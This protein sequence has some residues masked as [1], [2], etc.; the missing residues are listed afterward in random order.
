M[1]QKS[2]GAIDT[3]ITPFWRTDLELHEW[4]PEPWKS[5]RQLP[6]ML[7]QMYSAPTGIPPYGEYLEQAR[8]DG[9]PRALPGSSMA[10]VLAKMDAD[11][12]RLGILMPLTRGPQPDQDMSSVI[13]S[14]TN[15]WLSETWLDVP[16]ADG[17]FLGTIRVNPADPDTAV[18]E[19]QRWA[20]HPRMVQVGV[21][22]DAWRPYGQ[23]NY[24]PIWEAA[25]RYDLPIAV[26]ADGGASANFAPTMVGYPRKHI[27]Y[28]SQ[29]SINFTYHLASF[30]MEGVFERLPNLR[31]VFADGGHDMVTTL[32]WRMDADFAIARHEVPWMTKPPGDYLHHFRFRTSRLEGPAGAD[33]VWSKLS[34]ASELLMFGSNYPHWTSMGTDQVLEG[35][36]DSER[37][38]VLFGNAAEIYTPRLTATG[39]LDALTRYAAGTP[40]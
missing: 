25:A 20:D 26:H 16:E 9:D 30:I 11:G 10:K 36:T 13:C 2:R 24:F 39:G 15:D 5:K 21:P 8:P 38:R 34:R 32:M 6:G 35:F 37:E 31:V 28:A 19:I 18:E 40:A 1:D 22:L 7:R 33:E 14:A 17:R 4:I 27:E 23:R 12:S 3:C 29:E